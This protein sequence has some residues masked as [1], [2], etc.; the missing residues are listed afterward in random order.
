MRIIY[1]ILFFLFYMKGYTQLVEVRGYALDTLSNRE[2]FVISIN[3][4]LNKYS[5]QQ[6]ISDSPSIY[7]KIRERYTTSTKKDGSFAIKAK[8]EDSLYV[9][10]HLSFTRYIPQVHLVKDLMAMDSVYV[11][12]EPE[13]CVKYVKCEDENPKLYVFVG[14]VIEVTEVEET[15]YCNYINMDFKF[16]AKLKILQD[17]HGNYTKDTIEFFAYDHYG[18]PN[19]ASHSHVLIYVSEYCGNL[20]HLK[21]QFQPVYKVEGKWAT[22]YYTRNNANKELYLEKAR[23]MKFPAHA[24]FRVHQRISDSLLNERYHSPYF[25]KKDSIFKP[26]YGFYAEDFFSIMKQTYFKKHRHT[27]YS[28][29]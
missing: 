29:D 14:E 24:S 22:P 19:F 7:H 1:V 6:N 13:E 10:S 18:V 11:F 2:V 17:L 26:L 16:E 15:Y 12:L 25:L 28:L 4:T 9:D 23:P 21:Y 8:L 3:D 5:K 27:N 20:F